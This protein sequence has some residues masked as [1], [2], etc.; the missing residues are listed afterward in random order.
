M[1]EE[2]AKLFRTIQITTGGNTA[3]HL[4]GWTADWSALSIPVIS[5]GVPMAIPQSAL[6]P[7]QAPSREIFISVMAH[8]VVAAAGTIIAYAIM[9]VCLPTASREDCF[10][11]AKINRDPLANGILA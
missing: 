5:V 3:P 11:L 7:E 9:R 10:V 1:A 4:A 6:A 8:D 2:A